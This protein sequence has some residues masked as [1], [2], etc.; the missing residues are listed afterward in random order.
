MT[1][2]LILTAY[3]KT[4]ELAIEILKGIPLEE[5]HKQWKENQKFW[6]DSIKFWEDLFKK[7]QPP[8]PNA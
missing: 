4:I 6:Q 5:R 7:L 8:T 2:D 1:P 3:I